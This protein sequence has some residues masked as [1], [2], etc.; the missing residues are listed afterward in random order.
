MSET[1]ELTATRSEAALG[2]YADILR[3]MAAKAAAEGDAVHGEKFEEL[4][5]KVEQGK[6]TLAFCGHFS[7]GKSTLVNALCGAKLLPSSPIPTSANVVT[8]A[9]GEPAA[10][11]VFRAADGTVAVQPEMPVERLND[12]AID[13]EGVASI[14]VTYP[15]PLLGSHLAFVDTPGVDSTD[16][17]HRAATESALHLADVVFY[18]TDY[19]HV[20]SEVNF[21]FLRT[22][23]RWG[24]PTYLIVNQVD[25]HREQEVAF[26][27]FQEGVRQALAHWRI[28]PAGVLYLSLREPAHPLSQWDELT[29]IIERLKPLREQLLLYSADR[30]ARHLAERHRDS[31]RQQHLIEREALL[32]RLG[33]EEGAKRVR[34]GRAE[35]EARLTQV[36]TEADKRRDRFR[37]ELDKLLGN[38]NLTPAETR[39]KA[40]AALESM[41]P[42]FKVGWFGSAAKTEAERQRRWR[43]LTDSFNAQLDANVHGHVRE[44][45]R[46]EAKED[47]LEGEDLEAAL[48]DAF[49]LADAEWLK[50]RVKPGAGADGQ[51][52]L[53]FAAE[54]SS[55]RKAQVRKEAL[56]F[57]ERL[58]EAREPQ[59]QAAEAE[60]KRELETLAEQERW[61]RRLDALEERERAAEA[62][63]LAM[64]PEPKLV[65]AGTLPEP[66]EA[67][68]DA[69]LSIGRP[70]AKA[71]AGANRA[72][73]VALKGGA[74]GIGDASNGGTA[75]GAAATGAREGGA[76]AAGD[77]DSVAAASGTQEAA[78]LL[79]KAAELLEPLAPLRKQ[80]AGLREKAKR[81]RE[82]Q[83]TIALFGA[84]SAG[85]S[86]F[87]NSLVGLPVLPVS[88]NPTTATINRIVAPSDSY[89]HG[90]A[91]IRMKSAEDML[92]DIRHSLHRLGAS[93]LDIAAAGDDAEQLLALAGSMSPEELHPRGRPHLAFLLAAAKGWPQ[94][95]GLLGQELHVGED[96]YRRYV[97]EEEASCFVASVDL[98][99]DAPLTRSGAVLVDTPGADSINARHTGVS[100]QYIKDADAVLFVTYYNHAFTEA[101]RGFL[102]QLGS[103]K[104]AFEL[105]KMFFIVNAADLAA[106]SEELTAVLGHVEG[107]LLKHG[108]RNPRLFPVSSLN[109]L[110]AK[111]ERSAEGLRSSGLEAFEAAF[112]RFSREELG[113]LA[114]Q[115][116]HKELDRIDALMASLLQ[117]ANEDAEAR[118]A[119][120][121]R[122]LGE[123]AGL[124][125]R[126]LSS[127]SFAGVQPLVQ[128]TSDQLY[129]LRQRVK[130]RFNDH[131]SAAFHPSVL[132][133]DGR[134]LKKML[135]A[136]WADL[137]RSV[138]EDL[139]Q[140]LRAAGLRLEGALH[141]RIAEKVAEEA[142]NA[143]LDGF[144]PEQ[145]PKPDLELPISEPFADPPPID[146]RRLWNAFRSP[147]YFF[148]KDGKTALRDDLE[149]ELFQTADRWLAETKALWSER[150][151]EVY[152]LSLYAAAEG[153][154]A[155]LE[156]FAAGLEASLGQS[157]E[158]RIWAEI[159]GQWTNLRSSKS[160]FLSHQD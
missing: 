79:A 72:Q 128:E 132:Q 135:Q 47:G 68:G 61:V 90:T 45:L 98:H 76:V 149:T 28:E 152:R 2:A 111:L 102:N 101:D 141:K 17:A 31:I 104:D 129:H 145:P 131:F 123:A 159:Y 142:A 103:V 63:L 112:W 48:A 56:R 8:I 83:F 100:F 125:E 50:A 140:E 54:L 147:K 37:E 95:G 120:K 110:A 10:R 97:A 64:L 65:A 13:G 138:G 134:D 4:A 77:S 114:V 156:A 126:L 133:D 117:S 70:Q 87:A 121:R 85:K 14:E 148:E 1:T 108:I 38:A 127:L 155:E 46:K 84:F 58:E 71:A 52:T 62:E 9:N 139:L 153:L 137:V 118:D 88:P 150:I 39:E 42:N 43:E 93:D 5:Q 119:R 49:P 32:E 7:A 157:G 115:A 16:G 35:L 34:D 11:V 116:A 73:E 106:S 99:I 96:E 27:S 66:K 60:V 67:G 41:Q 15:V 21:R 18:V 122:M 59:R 144:A 26:R 94:Y 160:C 109:G 25:K 55:D 158:E 29:G 12:W 113:G 136:C 22:L 81:L 36:R 89:P 24:K 74:Q 92:A 3:R 40:R 91:L 86:S 23:H 80:A 78:A 154:V 53:H 20:L 51:A 6:L 107:Q 105:D 57:Y 44:M 19:N 33:G 146:G 130:Y 75:S 69:A 151:T 124:K 82:R 30:S 143:A